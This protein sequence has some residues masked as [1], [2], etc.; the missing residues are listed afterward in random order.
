MLINW[1]AIDET[2][3]NAAV[4]D[5]AKEVD[6]ADVFCEQDE[7][8]IKLCSRVDI[9]VFGFVFHRQHCFFVGHVDVAHVFA[10][11]TNRT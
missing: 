5:G 11:E 9:S 10:L 6:A 1:F 4:V 7:T 2:N 3:L 8:V